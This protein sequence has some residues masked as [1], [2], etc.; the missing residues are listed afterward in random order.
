MRKVLRERFF[1]GWFGKGKG[2]GKELEEERVVMAMGV[3]HGKM[4]LI[5][6]GEAA[7]RAEVV[8]GGVGLEG[9]GGDGDGEDLKE[10]GFRVDL[11]SLREARESPEIKYRAVL[12]V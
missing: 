10:R 4:E 7:E 11:V 9:L 6:L 8:Y 3:T 5:G 1:P 12:G 2:K